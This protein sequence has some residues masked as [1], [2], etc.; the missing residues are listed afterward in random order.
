MSLTARVIAPGCTF[1]G[2]ASMQ[3]AGSGIFATINGGSSAGFYYDEDLG[4]TGGGGNNTV[5]TVN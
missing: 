5:A 2:G 4:G 3:Y 1:N